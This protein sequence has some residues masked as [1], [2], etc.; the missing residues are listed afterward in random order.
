MSSKS[1]RI[2]TELFERARAHGEVVSR[3]A[4]QQVEHWARLG[5]A[6]EAA[7][8]TVTDVVEMLRSH[9]ASSASLSPASEQELWSFKRAQQSQDLEAVTA[10][11][12]SNDQM[13][14]FAGGKAK[15]AKL[16]GSP[17]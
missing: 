8:L 1:I 5:A 6:V 11:R 4:A 16:V 7:G 15:A 10:R 13:S 2:H 14:W 3:S 17:Y 9:Q 12:A